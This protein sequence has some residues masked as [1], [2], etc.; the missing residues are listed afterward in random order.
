MAHLYVHFRRDLPDDLEAVTDGRRIWMRDDLSQVE[1]RCVLAHELAHL[2]RGQTTCQ[3]DVVER[4]VDNH[5]A[6]FL[7]PDI[8]DVAEAL[9]WAG[10]RLHEAAEDLWVTEET[11]RARLDPRHLHPAEHAI[12]RDRLGSVSDHGA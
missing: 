1:R 9:V 3:P 10:C 11:L 12:L 7:L 8:H 6:R 2:E 4:A 5:A